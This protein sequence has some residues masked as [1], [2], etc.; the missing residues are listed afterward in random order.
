M[1]GLREFHYVITLQNP[2]GAGVHLQTQEG[3]YSA[4]PGVTRQ[5]AYIQIVDSL[6]RPDA[7][8]MFFSLEPN[9]LSDS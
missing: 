6:N 5:E 1:D 4:G 9:R 8:V 7:N 2:V 3:I